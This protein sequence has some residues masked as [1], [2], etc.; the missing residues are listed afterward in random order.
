[1][2]D[3]KVLVGPLLELGVELLVVLVAHLLVGAVEVLHV[4][5][6]EV[7]GG[8][9]SAAT[10]PPNTAVRLEVAIVEVHGRGH[11]VARVHHRGEPAREE[12]HALALLVALGT[13]DAALRS[14]RERLLRH[15]AIHDGE[16]AAGLLKDV[17][18]REHAADAT[19]AALARPCVL[20]ELGAVDL[21]DCSADLVLRIAAH[22]LELGA[23]LRV[24]VGVVRPAKRLRGRINRLVCVPANASRRGLGGLHAAVG[25]A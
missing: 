17:A 24:G 12:G 10:E 21:L 20:A 14:R 1:M 6:E 5:L 22:L 3:Q 19:A 2:L 9:V 13:V 15:A 11:G 16:R 23:H 18:P 8:D 25:H 7:G 4:L